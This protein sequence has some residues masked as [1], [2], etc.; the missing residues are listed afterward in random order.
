MFSRLIPIDKQ[1]IWNCPSRFRNMTF[2]HKDRKHFGGNFS[3]KISWILRTCLIFRISDLICAQRIQCEILGRHVF[4][5]SVQ[6][7][8]KC[9]INTRTCFIRK[10]RPFYR[11]YK[12]TNFH[13]DLI[14]SCHFVHIVTSRW[15]S[16]SFQL[17]FVMFV[18]ERKGNIQG[19]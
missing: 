11:F 18:L 6:S 10:T 2:N 1:T 7:C 13:K 4:S 19:K 16:S 14:F 15:S 17:L 5:S 9:D 8:E 12:V 3:V